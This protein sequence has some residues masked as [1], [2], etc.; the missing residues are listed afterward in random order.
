M[1]AQTRA[2][3]KRDRRRAITEVLRILKANAR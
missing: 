2:P 1:I 3:K